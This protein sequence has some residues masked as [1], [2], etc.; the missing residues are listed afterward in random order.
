MPDSPGGHPARSK[1]SSSAQAGTFCRCAKTFCFAPTP[2]DS[3]ASLSSRRGAD[4]LRP[5]EESMTMR[6]PLL[7]LTRFL[8]VAATLAFCSIALA[9]EEAI[10]LVAHPAFRDLEYRH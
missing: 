10:L 8:L 2:R 4:I 5:N 6:V 7:G 1:A 3:G 9:Q